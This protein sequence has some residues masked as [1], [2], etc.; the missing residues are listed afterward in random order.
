MKAKKIYDFIIECYIAL[1]VTL[2][3]L[4]VIIKSVTK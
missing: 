3:I 4:S 2:I 1:Y